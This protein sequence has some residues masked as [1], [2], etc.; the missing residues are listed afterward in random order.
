MC[1][2][3]HILYL[4]SYM[5]TLELDCLLIVRSAQQDGLK[6]VYEQKCSQKLLSL[7]MPLIANLLLSK[8][9]EVAFSTKNSVRMIVISYTFLAARMLS[10]LTHISIH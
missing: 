4:R 10:I 3:F 8:E 5:V 2:E 7:T 6:I 1:V 9:A